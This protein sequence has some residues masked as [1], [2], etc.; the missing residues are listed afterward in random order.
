M[1]V[2]INSI[3][4]AG[5]IG[6]QLAANDWLQFL[7]VHVVDEILPR[8]PH[9]LRVASSAARTISNVENICFDLFVLDR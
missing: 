6:M 8:P 9:M 2:V 4:Y 5:T 7:Y 3:L 1:Q